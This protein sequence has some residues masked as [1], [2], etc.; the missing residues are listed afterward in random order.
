MDQ[1]VNNLLKNR[2]LGAS[3]LL[4]RFGE[5]LPR[6]GEAELFSILAELKMTFPLMA[7]WHF[8][9]NY[10]QKHAPEPQSFEKFN[11]E[12]NREKAEVVERA[13]EQMSFYKTCLTLSRSSLVE[14]FLLERNKLKKVD[15]ICS[16]SLPAGEG[17]HLN[18]SL[19]EA[20]L[21]SICVPD[22]DL[23]DKLYAAD[24]LILGADWVSD[25]L[26]INKQGS[27]KIVEAATRLDM[28]IFILA[29]RFKYMDPPNISREAFIQDW[30]HAGTKRFIKVF[31]VFP[32]TESVRLV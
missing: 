16:Q 17:V 31:E 8:A 6:Y 9:E 4:S 18:S 13:C 23:V 14:A 27:L 3:A 1:A 5:I 10:F 15:V 7:V 19:L 20:G 11:Q 21:N 25:T 29:E 22:W 32:R 28:P 2:D 26:I 30:S 12:L 24:V